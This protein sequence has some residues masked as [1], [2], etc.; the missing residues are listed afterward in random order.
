V[1][2]NPGAEQIDQMNLVLANLRKLDLAERQVVL[3]RLQEGLS[4]KEISR[5]TGRTEGNVGCLLHHAVKKLS[6]CVKTESNNSAKK[7]GRKWE[8]DMNRP[9]DTIEPLLTAYLLGDLNPADTAAV[10]EHLETCEACRAAARELEP[11]LT[12][13]R[14]ALAADTPRPRQLAPNAA[15]ESSRRGTRRAKWS[16]SP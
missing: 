11:T 12:L 14:G 5:I 1:T 15:P 16:D 4:Y 6:Q 7:T 10:R 8:P 2:E 3:L 13:L 9:C